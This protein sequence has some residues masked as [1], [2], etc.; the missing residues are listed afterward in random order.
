MSEVGVVETAGNINQTAVSYMQS[1]DRFIN[2]AAMKA[3]TDWF[4]DRGTVQ[5]MRADAPGW[6]EG[7]EN[8]TKIEQMRGAMLAIQAART[9]WNAVGGG[10]QLASFVWGDG[11]GGVPNT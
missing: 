10:R 9:A 1:F 6:E 11:V 2:D 3:A 5:Q 7:P 4:N 8:D